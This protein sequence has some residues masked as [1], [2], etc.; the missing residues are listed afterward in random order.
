M[1]D[2]EKLPRVRSER[3]SSALSKTFYDRLGGALAPIVT[4]TARLSGAN[5]HPA[6]ND[7]LSFS[8]IFD[9]L[10]LLG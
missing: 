6:S 5:D 10:P 8:S 1:Y 9:T 3:P 2:F 7:T 4:V